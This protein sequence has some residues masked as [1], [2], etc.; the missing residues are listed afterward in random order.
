MPPP[1]VAMGPRANGST[2]SLSASDRPPSI[3]ARS[4]AASWPASRG[5]TRRPGITTAIS[6][7]TSPTGTRHDSGVPHA[8]FLLD[9]D[10]RALEVGRH[11]H[12]IDGVHR[13]RDIRTRE[14]LQRQALDPGSEPLGRARA[15]RRRDRHASPRHGE[16]PGAGRRSRSPT[17]RAARAPWHVRR[18]RTARRRP[19]PGTTGSLGQAEAVSQPLADEDRTGQTRHAP[20]GELLPGDVPVAVAPVKRDDDRAST[21]RKGDRPRSS[22]RSSA[23]TTSYALMLTMRR[24]AAPARHS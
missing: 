1:W 17:G 18:A 4:K 14:V 20:R 24:Q 7:G 3:A 5:A 10:G 19:P 22:R 23:W 12:G 16:S 8:G 11:E 9:R 6:S 21:L 13:Q 2:R 15:S